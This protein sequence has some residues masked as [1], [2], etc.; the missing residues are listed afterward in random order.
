MEDALRLKQEAQSHQFLQNRTL[1]SAATFHMLRRVRQRPEILPRI[2]G[3]RLCAILSYY[4]YVTD[5][6]T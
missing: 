6:T 4:C 1:H 5:T 2:N 3:M